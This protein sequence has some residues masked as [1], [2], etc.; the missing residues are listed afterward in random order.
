MSDKA[1]T[2]VV[3]ATVLLAA[4]VAAAIIVPRLHQRTAM[5]QPQDLLQ[6][7]MIDQT[8]GWAL[9][10][11]GQIYRT[12]NG[13]ATW[14][15]ISAFQPGPTADNGSTIDACFVDGQTAFAAA[16]TGTANQPTIVVFRTV[17]QG[18][19][20]NSTKISANLSWEKDDVGGVKL[21]F[22]DALNG[23][24][25]VTGTPG[26]GQMGKAL[27]QT[28]DGGKT[29]SFVGDIT[30]MT[31]AKGTMVGVEGYPDGMTF[32]TP[33]LGFVTCPAGAWMYLLMFK[34]TDGGVTWNLMS[35][36]VPAAYQSLS[37]SNDYFANPY[38]PAFFGAQ[39]NEGV[40]MVDFFTQ[41]KHVMQSYHTMDGG[42]S[43]TVGPVSGN[44]S[45]TT[46]SFINET[47]G[48]GLDQSGKVFTTA[49]GGAT[50][51]A[52]ASNRE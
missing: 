14:T 46:Y 32:S 17:D 1:R 34:T 43:W 3:L 41:D 8:T 35:L 40:M 26:A 48:W 7:A 27:Y 30:G 18:T 49:D 12:G 10:K 42:V 39:K 22:P 13:G 6:I 25:M 33:K 20:W 23:F 4:I 16:N 37:Y 44:T 15:Q 36:P 5:T 9:A 51:T 31:N 28:T 38:P 24:L 47:T 21:S 2:Q 50:W 11:N 52:I 19:T 29:F 45:V